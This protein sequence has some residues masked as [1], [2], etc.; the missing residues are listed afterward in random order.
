MSISLERIESYI[1]LDDG[2]FL[3]EK[4]KWTVLA[5]VKFVGTSWIDVAFTKISVDG[6]DG[7]D[8]AERTVKRLMGNS[9]SAVIFLDGITYAGFNIVDPD[10]LSARTDLIVVAVFMRRPNE[11]RILKALKLHFPDWEDRWKIIHRVSSKLS[12]IN[13]RGRTIYFYSSP[14]KAG[15]SLL[16]RKNIVTSKVP[17][18]LRIADMLAKEIGKMFV[19]TGKGIST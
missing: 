15:I 8:S 10:E 16:I 12:E 17:E 2:M 3:K 11:E 4:S 18:P 5:G 19:R 14:N 9:E 1:G 13:V 6:L 7:T